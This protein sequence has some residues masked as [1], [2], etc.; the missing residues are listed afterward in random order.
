[1]KKIL[2]G[3]FSALFFSMAFLS[4]GLDTFYVLNP[5][6]DRGSSGR[7]N[8]LNAQSDTNYVDFCS[9]ENQSNDLRFDGSYIYYKIYS[10][11]DS[12][13]SAFTQIE[14]KNND[15]SSSQA[16]TELER[17][18]YKQLYYVRTGSTIAEP[19]KVVSN[20]A[21][22]DSRNMVYV[23]IRLTDYL[24]SSEP[25]GDNLTA[26]YIQE[27][28]LPESAAEIVGVP[29]REISSGSSKKLFNFGWHANS[30]YTDICAEPASGDSDLSGNT[31][32]D[33]KYYVDLWA[34]GVGYDTT[35]T[36]YYS[37]L[38]H[39]GIIKINSQSER[40]W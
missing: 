23:R 26:A 3:I 33:G 5:P 25:A 21:H 17:L 15:S 38:V 2:S 28:K 18:S 13:K 24:S 8:I 19:Y 4:C 40:N 10:N 32:S 30:G 20:N 1:M 27:G 12:C 14:S 6:E 16:Y 22:K 11:D 7:A 39:L 9:N 37:K 31:S 36:K 34:A 29:A 35:F